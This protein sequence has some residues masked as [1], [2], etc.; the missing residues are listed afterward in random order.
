MTRRNARSAKARWRTV[1]RRDVARDEKKASEWKLWLRDV[2]VAVAILV[3]VLL[4]MYA[5]TGVW[6]P[7]VVVES[8]SMQHGDQTSYIGVIDTGDLVFVQ[9]APQRSDVITYIEGRATG[10]STY[11]DYGDV[12]IFH[13]NADVSVTP[14]IHR[15]MLWVRPNGTGLVDVPDLSLLPLADWG[16]QSATGQ[17]TH[18]PYHIRSA[19]IR[20]MGFN[21]DLNISFAFDS[22]TG[23]GT[24]GPGFV[25][26]GDNN[27]FH[28]CQ[29]GVPCSGGYDRGWFAIQSDIIGHARGEIPW[30]GLL[31]LLLSPASQG[32]CNGW[33]DP[34]APPN[35]WTDLA[36][37]I[38]F[39]VALPFILEGVVWAWGK[40]AWPWLRPRLLDRGREEDDDPGEPVSHESEDED[41][42]D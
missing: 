30:F 11:G 24:R 37:A 10:Y 42:L 12:I 21:H 16:A 20:G 14:I 7:L 27:A 40:Y 38:A 2:G 31:K 28:E 34:T 8:Q 26:M 23:L 13:P 6:P 17:P 35:S 19:W 4:G 36:V 9:G 1:A 25:T 5:Y 39:L 32:C 33:G 22:I 15:A 18:S 29:S 41:D 3:F